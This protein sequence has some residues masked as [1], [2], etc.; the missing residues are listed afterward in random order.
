MLIHCIP[1][2]F[3]IIMPLNESHRCLFLNTT[4]C[5]IGQQQYVYISILQMTFGIIVATIT[6]I[7][8]ETFSLSNALHAFA[9]F[10]LAS[11]RME[12]ILIGNDLQMS[13][14]KKYVLY[15]DKIA[16]A[17]DIH[18]RA[19]EFSNL[20]VATFGTP[21]LFLFILSECSASICLF[22]IL[23]MRLRPL[24]IIMSVLCIFCNFL[25]LIIGNFVGQIFINYDTYIYERL[26]NIRWY[27]IPLKAQK[28][29]LFMMQKA[30][31]SYKVDAGGMFNPSLKGLATTM[32]LMYSFVMMLTSM[33]R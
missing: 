22:L 26:C 14:T 16:A 6:G 12:R 10:K 23:T 30:T 8:T 5:F 7:A 3:L 15:R 11:Y 31:R 33:Q 27:N 32:S 18:K 25:F 17:V 29:I 21:Y 4:K 9:L 13:A 19:T 28:L 2:S 20:L 1:N 24:E